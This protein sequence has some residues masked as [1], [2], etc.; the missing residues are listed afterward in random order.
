VQTAKKP[1]TRRERIARFV[2]M[3]ARHETIHP[4]VKKR[5]SSG[6]L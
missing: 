2:A 3:C 6:I 1:E 5:K 4:P